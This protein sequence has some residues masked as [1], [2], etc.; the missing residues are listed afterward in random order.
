MKSVNLTEKHQKPCRASKQMY[1][2]HTYKQL[3]SR[4]AGSQREA[5]SSD[6]GGKGE[7]NYPVRESSGLFEKADGELLLLD[8]SD[9]I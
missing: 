7:N 5:T 8:F 3:L 1:G 4:C 2:P 6:K 9:D